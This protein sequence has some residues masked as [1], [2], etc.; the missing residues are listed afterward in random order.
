LAKK[1]DTLLDLCVSSLRRG[2]ANLLCIVPILTDDPR[3]E[4]K[5]HWA[6]HRSQTWCK[7]FM[8][9][10]S[11]FLQLAQQSRPKLL[12]A[13][14]LSQSHI[15]WQPATKHYKSSC[16]GSILRLRII[17]PGSLLKPDYCWELGIACHLWNL[18]DEAGCACQCHAC[19]WLSQAKQVS[20]KGITL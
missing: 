13:S 18:E 3:R 9:Y 1:F 2:H 19:G 10:Y 15:K 11:I 12:D 7:L 20:H 17:Q 6:A 14:S 4:S 8:H 5:K 16:L